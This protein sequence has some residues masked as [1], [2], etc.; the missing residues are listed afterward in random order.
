MIAKRKYSIHKDE[1]HTVRKSFRTNKNFMDKIFEIQQYY[2]S[3][4]KRKPTMTTIIFMAVYHFSRYKLKG[5]SA[6]LTEADMD[7]LLDD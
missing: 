1:R 6:G 5:D 4:G 7:I 2:I 3:K